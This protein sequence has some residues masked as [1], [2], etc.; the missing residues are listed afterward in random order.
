MRSEYSPQFFGPLYPVLQAIKAAFD[1][2]NQLNPGKIAAPG[3]GA[4]RCTIDGMP[5][6]GQFD[7]TIPA[8]VRAGFDEALA[9]Q[10]QRR[11]L[12]LGPGRRH[13][14]VLEG[15]ARAAALAQGARPADARMAAAAGRA[16]R[17]PGRGGRRLRA[18]ARAGARCPR[19]LRNSLRKS[20][21]TD[22]SHEV[23][24]AMD[25]CLACKSCVGQCPIKVDVPTF[26]SKF[27]ELYHGRYLR[28]PARLRGRRHRAPGA[29]MA[30]L[31]GLANVARRRRAG[32]CDSCARS[33]SCHTPQLSGV[34]H[35]ARLERRGV[36]IALPQALRALDAGRAPGSVVIVQDA[37]TSHYETR[38]LLDLIDLL[39]Q[40]G[41]KPW[42]APFRPNGKALHVHGFL[43]AFERVAAANA[44]ML[45][46]SRRAGST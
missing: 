25:G 34:K 15:H 6:K 38:L 37:F 2:R 14:P 12:Q 29:L 41:L 4:A 7:R 39:H 9:L 36:R 45:R 11:L 22:F 31:P 40:I 1:P 16:G 35:E 26:R 21:E 30:R 27:L 17:R 44:R 10:R 23:K 32:P 18:G 8:A 20:R 24:E 46:R 19:R 5:M 42:L 43:G 28:P 13:V 3:D 33:G